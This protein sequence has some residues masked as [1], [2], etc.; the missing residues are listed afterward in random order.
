MNVANIEQLTYPA[1]R[2]SHDVAVKLAA[3]SDDERAGIAVTVAA[4]VPDGKISFKVPIPEWLLLQPAAR[5]P[6]RYFGH[7]RYLEV[8]SCVH[9]ETV[10]RMDIGYGDEIANQQ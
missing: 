5:N 9:N 3:M 8:F 2:D 1:G 7:V 10:G 6:N 4:A